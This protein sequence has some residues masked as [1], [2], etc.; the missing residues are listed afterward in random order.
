MPDSIY[1]TTVTF[2]FLFYQ[3]TQFLSL[4]SGEE[5]WTWRIS[6]EGVEKACGKVWKKDYYEQQ[7]E[8]PPFLYVSG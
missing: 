3:K 2:Y 4:R 7:N 1:T 8:F 5:C 6:E